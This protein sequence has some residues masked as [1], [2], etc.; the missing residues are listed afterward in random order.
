MSSSK[1]QQ[2][3]HGGDK[4][5]IS[6]SASAIQSAPH[7][8]ANAEPAYLEP[9]SGSLQKPIEG[10]SLLALSTTISMQTKDS[11]YSKGRGTPAAN[12]KLPVQQYVQR[13]SLFKFLLF[14]ASS[15]ART[16]S[17]KVTKRN[18]VNPIR[19]LISSTITL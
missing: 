9:N 19:F 10:L 6:R 16:I 15:T 7:W 18:V 8:N 14:G 13:S 17:S 4:R 12:Q 1:F 3:F 2:A 5:R 11:A